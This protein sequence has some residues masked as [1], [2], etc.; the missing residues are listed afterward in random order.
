[1]DKGC[2]GLLITLAD[3]P[4]IA[5]EEL[6]ALLK[7]GLANNIAAAEYGDRVG[8]PAYFDSSY[9]SRLLILQGDL[10]AGKLLNNEKV[11]RCKFNN[12]SDM[13]RPPETFL[14]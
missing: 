1:M 6:I 8:V 11:R 10:G 2:N 9:F 5:A 4:Y 7:S 14:Q 13:D 12:L 3:Q